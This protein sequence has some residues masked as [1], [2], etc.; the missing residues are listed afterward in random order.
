MNILLSDYC[1]EDCLWNIVKEMRKNYLSNLELITNLYDFMSDSF[2]LTF[3][4]SSDEIIE[5][6]TN[7]DTLKLAGEMFIY[8]TFCP[9]KIMTFYYH[10]FKNSTTK[11]ILLALNNILREPSSVIEQQSAEKV[12][13]KV[14]KTLDLMHYEDIL[15]LVNGTDN[16]AAHNVTGLYHKIVKLAFATS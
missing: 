3:D 12:W 15:S 11:T 9:P 6:V 10:L 5:Y 1:N 7:E 4:N 16:S 14:T 2:D 8:L 13:F